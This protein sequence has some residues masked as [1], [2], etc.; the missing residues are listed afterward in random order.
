MLLLLLLLLLHVPMQ[1]PD[2]LKS[3]SVP[4]LFICPE[5]DAWFPEKTKAAAQKM[6]E[7]KKPGKQSSQ[8][9]YCPWQDQ[10]L[11]VV[12]GSIAMVSL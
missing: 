7:E 2:E 10:N 8:A 12:L 5:T 9:W 4:L 11:L 3:A 1:I 6:L